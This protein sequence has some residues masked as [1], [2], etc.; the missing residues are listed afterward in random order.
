MKNLEVKPILTTITVD[1]SFEER[2][3]LSGLFKQEVNLKF[4]YLKFNFENH[5]LVNIVGTNVKSDYHFEVLNMTIQEIRD[6]ILETIKL[7]KIPVIELIEPSQ[8]IKEIFLKAQTELDLELESKIKEIQEKKKE[9]EMDM[10]RVENWDDVRKV[11]KYNHLG[12][13]LNEDI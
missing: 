1:G 7:V 11:M 2:Q 13:L 5:K 9:L 4:N 8:E 12:Y 10:Y 6:E 3:Y